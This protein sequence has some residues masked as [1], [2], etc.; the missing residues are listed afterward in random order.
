MNYSV[1]TIA[2]VSLLVGRLSSASIPFDP[3]LLDKSHVVYTTGCKI[4]NPVGQSITIKSDRLEYRPLI[5]TK[6]FDFEC[7][8]WTD[9]FYQR[10]P[11]HMRIV[12]HQRFIRPTQQSPLGGA[13]YATGPPCSVVQPVEIYWPWG[14][15]R[16]KFVKE[17]R[18]IFDALRVN[19]ELADNC[20]AHGSTNVTDAAAGFL[21]AIAYDYRIPLGSLSTRNNMS[22]I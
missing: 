22:T 16:P 11:H 1:V 14:P 9:V 7:L 5:F 6:L 15:T 3:A 10:R 12:K 4:E 21:Y 18:V 8:P 17:F 19:K 2:F 13:P 20:T